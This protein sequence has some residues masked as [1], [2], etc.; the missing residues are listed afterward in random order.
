MIMKSVLKVIVFGTI[1][2]GLSSCA[3]IVGGSKYIARVIVA[4]RP[5]A[6]ITY[7]GVAMGS[8]TAVMK[9]PR[10]KANTFSV[11]V[12]EEG[13]NEQ[14]FNFTQRTFRGWAFF[15][16]IVGWT[17]VAGGIPLPWG[18]V[19]DLSDGSLWKPSILEKGVSKMD[20]KNYVYSLNYKAEKSTVIVLK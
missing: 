11:S 4:N 17:G 13:Y 18:V 2:L 8:G 20:Y 1:L 12:K 5:N 14:I 10:S 15:G 16:T 19:V 9:V 7:Q 6:S 3:T